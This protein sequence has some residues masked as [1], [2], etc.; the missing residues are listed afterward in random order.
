MVAP[1]DPRQQNYNKFSN[2][3]G[4]SYECIRYLMKNDEEI[5][6]LLYYNDADCWNKTN[7]TESQKA[8]IIYDGTPDETSFRVF[9]DP[10]QDNSW[11]IQACVLRVTPIL[12][13][14][15][16]Y[17]FGTMCVGFEVYS[18]YKINHTSAYKTRLDMITQRIIEVFNGAEIPNLG[19]LFFDRKASPYCKILTIGSIPYKGRAIYL[20]TQSLG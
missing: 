5:W 18:H 12:A 1:Y 16:N 3:D 11:T 2:F 17:V 6:K 19:R 15:D 13:T 10:G 14:P 4:I 7:L 9:M 8:G 20:C